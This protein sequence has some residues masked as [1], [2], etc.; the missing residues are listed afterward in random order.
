MCSPITCL[1][2]DYVTRASLKL[3]QQLVDTNTE[4]LV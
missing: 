3:S 1:L 4:Q 2:L